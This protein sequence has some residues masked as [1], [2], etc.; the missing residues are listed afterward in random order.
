MIAVARALVLV[1]NDDRD[2]CPGGLA[3]EHAG[4][5][6][7]RVGFFALRY[8]L[9]LPGAPALQIRDDVFLREGN[10][11][12]T[13]VDDHHVGRA[14]AFARSGHAERSTERTTRHESSLLRARVPADC[15]PNEERPHLL[16]VLR[17]LHRAAHRLDDV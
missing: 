11:R 5:N 16:D 1:A 6:L 3:F 13:T 17:G 10:T 8:D 7:R 9:A 2:G 12:R 14:V 15:A 4:K